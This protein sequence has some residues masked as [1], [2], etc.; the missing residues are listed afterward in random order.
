MDDIRTV[1]IMASILSAT[2]PQA[3]AGDRAALAQERLAA[4]AWDLYHA[5][6][7]ASAEA[8]R[9]ASVGAAQAGKP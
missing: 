7:R 5:V 9:R 6:Q 8:A 3:P 4:E 2:R 1:A